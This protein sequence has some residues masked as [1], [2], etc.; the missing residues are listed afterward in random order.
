VSARGTQ[1][2]DS[3]R[4]VKPQLTKEGSSGIPVQPTEVH[5]PKTT[6]IISR[7]LELICSACYKLITTGLVRGEV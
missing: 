3:R 7:M 6:G 5:T 4:P 2:M 1:T